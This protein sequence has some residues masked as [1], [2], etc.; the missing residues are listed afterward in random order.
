LKL[1][2]EAA[3]RPGESRRLLRDS[4]GGT[5]EPSRSPRLKFNRERGFT[6]VELLVVLIIMG[7]ILTALTTLFVR[8]MKAELEA[9]QRFRAQDQARLAVDRMRREIHCASAITATAS[10]VSATVPGHCPSAVSATTTT[11]VYSFQ[12][13]GTNRY[14]LRRAVNGG[15]AATIADH[16]T[17]DNAFGYTEPSP[18]SL[19]K[20]NVDLRVNVKPNE[21][22]KTWRLQTDIVLRNTI[23]A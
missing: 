17:S 21:G 2:L 15:A 16:I 8:G 13:V 14:K 5:A 9:D 20:L 23:R 19:G 11:V 7:T 18:S 6:V 22:W 4:Y 3:E 12:S 10:S 1:V